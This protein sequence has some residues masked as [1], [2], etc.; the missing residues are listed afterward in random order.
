MQSYRHYAVQAH[1]SR[2]PVWYQSKADM[3]ISVS[4]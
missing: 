1:D 4:D 2:W 3:R